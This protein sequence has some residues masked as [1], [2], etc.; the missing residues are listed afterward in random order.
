MVSAGTTTGATIDGEPLIRTVGEW[1]DRAF[2][3]AQQ[4]G[5]DPDAARDV[6]ELACLRLTQNL[7]AMTDPAAAGPWLVDAVAAE[8][9]RSLTRLRERGQL[10][11]S[12]A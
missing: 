6:V 7:D 5:L 3:A 8:A 2:A 9:D 12:R 10:L 4:R 11:D 1:L